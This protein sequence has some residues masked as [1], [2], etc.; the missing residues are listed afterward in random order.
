M[1]C[2]SSPLPETATAHTVA[3]FAVPQL[4]ANHDTRLRLDG[5]MFH[6]HPRLEHIIG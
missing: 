6:C 4:I 2:R 3:E 5:L 1:I